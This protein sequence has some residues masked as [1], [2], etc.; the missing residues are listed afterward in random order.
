[1]ATTKKCKQV[2]R[3]LAAICINFYISSL[4]ALALLRE[5]MTRLCRKSFEKIQKHFSKRNG[6]YRPRNEN[7]SSV[8]DE[9]FLRREVLCRTMKG[10]WLREWGVERFIFLP[11]SSLKIIISISKACLQS[12][13]EKRKEKFAKQQEEVNEEVENPAGNFQLFTIFRVHFTLLSERTKE[14]FSLFLINYGNYSGCLY[15]ALGEEKTKLLCSDLWNVT[16]YSQSHRKKCL[17]A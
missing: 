16:V 5:K 17:L 14:F 15:Y 2:G 8:I 12:D 4:V 13:E 10:T 7:C 1:M 11:S 3:I 6:I 9:I